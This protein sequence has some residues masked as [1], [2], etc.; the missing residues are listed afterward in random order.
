M[1]KRTELSIHEET[2]R[3][4]KGILL[5]TRSQSGRAIYCVIPT[6][7]YYGKGKTMEAVERS[8]F[9]RDLGRGRTGPKGKAQEIF[10]AVK[11][12]CMMYTVMVDTCYHTLV[13]TCRAYTTRSELQ[14]KQW[15]L[16]MIL[17][18]TILMQ[19]SW[20][21]LCTCGG[22]VMRCRGTV[23]FLLFFCKPKTALK[24]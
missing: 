3:N 5:S 2:W 21:K 12:F 9:S 14:H 19:V 23:D 6:V 1:T 8:W 10:R 4:L 22:G 13:Q 17:Q 24:N 20:V 15:T 16:L 7:L 11:L 18:H